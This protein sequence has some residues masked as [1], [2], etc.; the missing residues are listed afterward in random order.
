MPQEPDV[1]VARGNRLAEPGREAKACADVRH[2]LCRLAVGARLGQRPRVLAA[3]VRACPDCDAAIDELAALRRWLADTRQQ[4]PVAREDEELKDLAQA[5][6]VRELEARLARDLHARCLGR[7]G[8]PREAVLD[9]LR[10]AHLL[11]HASGVSAGAWARLPRMLLGPASAVRRG[12]GLALA[13][14]LD[15]AGL[16]LALAWLA[17]LAKD[18]HHAHA[19]READRYL[20]VVEGDLEGLG[21]FVR[22]AGLTLERSAEGATALRHAPGRLVGNAPRE[23]WEVPCDPLG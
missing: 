4:V 11:R 13:A 7:R 9:D 20:A 21:A 16:D 8:R 10:R 6:I 15:P 14:R 1:A 12:A 3:H 19:Q 18:G 2:E 22:R 23:K 5:A 17:Q